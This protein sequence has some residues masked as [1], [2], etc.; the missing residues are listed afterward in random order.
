MSTVDLL[1]FATG[2]LTGA[3]L[4]S[5][6]SLFGVSIGVAAVVILT[7]LGEGARRYVV[8]QFSTLGTNLLAVVPGRTETT[9]MLPGVIGTP[10]DLTLD[11]ALAV[12]RGVAQ[13]RLVAP[14]AMGTDVVSHGELQRQ[15]AVIG[16]NRQYLEVRDLK[17]GYGSFLPAGELD[18]GAA[19]VVLGH[20]VARELFPVSE[21]VGSIVRVGEFR[22][23]VI[24][25]LAPTGTQLGVNLDE[26]VMVPTAT[27]MR[28]FDK[29]S[30][31]RLL[32]KVN[33][34]DDIETAREAVRQLLLERHGEE[35]FTVQTE[36]ALA[37]TFSSILSALT[38]ALAGIAAVSLSVAGL[39]IMNV[40]LVATSERTPEIGLLRALGAGR[41]QILSA[42]LIEAVLLAGCG[43]VLGLVLGG[44]AVR[45]MVGLFPALPAVPPLWAV[46][47]AFTV[48]L[49]VGAV[50]GLLPAR[51][52]ADLDPVEA[53]AK[54]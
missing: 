4:R 12:S 35:D 17:L 7:A 19:I 36:E 6:L 42:F 32:V 47:S 40:M 23:R 10:N 37:S 29:R 34:Y 3:R 25:V 33:A 43:G 13:A 39:G 5:L 46:I 41:R 16:T 22:M 1:R 9:G 14:I 11:D 20:A 2:A 8:D 24:G 27:A 49:L 52:A 45:L 30:L 53:L 26:L 54:S 21:P 38:F 31:F 18:R 15:V 51:R 48:S 50:F 44:L 28:M